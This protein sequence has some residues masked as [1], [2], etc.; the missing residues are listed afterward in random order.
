MINNEIINA[1]NNKFKNLKPCP[2]N[3]VLKKFIQ[4]QYKHSCIL[5]NKPQLLEK[6]YKIVQKPYIV[7]NTNMSSQYSNHMDSVF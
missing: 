4:N 6:T 7:T 1:T 3:V 5:R 2:N